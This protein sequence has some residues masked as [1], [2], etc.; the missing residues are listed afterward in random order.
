MKT[1]V[2]CLLAST[3]LF[4]CSCT[5]TPLQ[6]ELDR[7]DEV[8]ASCPIYEDR[9]SLEADRL[10]T[11]LDRAQGDSARWV[12]LDSLYRYYY[13]NSLDSAKL[14]SGKMM[15]EASTPG[16]RFVSRLGQAIILSQ[17]GAVEQAAAI[18]REIDTLGV[19]DSAL[20]R[21]YYH[22]GIIVYT[23][24][25]RGSDSPTEISQLRQEYARYRLELLTLDTLSAY[26]RRLKGQVQRN[27][28]KMEEA[29][30]TFSSLMDDPDVGFND[31]ASTAYNIATAHEMMGDREQQKLWLAR[32]AQYDFLAQD[33]E[34]LSLYS[35]AMLLYEDGDLDRAARY[36]QTNMM[37]VLDG[38]FNTRMS[39]SGKAQLMI[40]AASLRAEHRRR[41]LWL[42]LSSVITALLL[43]SVAF[44]LRYRSLSKRL[45]HLNADLTDAN[46]IK[47]NYVF[48]YMALSVN[49]LERQDEFRHSLLQT[50]KED[51]LP[52][53]RQRL[54]S[55]TESYQ[56][57]KEFYRIFDETFLGIYPDFVRRVNSLLKED[58]Q[59]PEPKG[60][61][62]TTEL[63]ILAAIRIGITDSGRIATFLKCSPATVY[64][65]RTKMRKWAVFTKEEFEERIKKI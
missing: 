56:A 53:V 43:V 35:L 22:S 17:F 5:R 8:I 63:R 54:R 26:A 34:Y 7:L 14:Y 60:K 13:H 30:C 24:L 51:G 37:D 21:E 46:I 32:S 44:F 62:L 27:S 16:Q 48:R 11:S 58:C 19:R 9:F 29:L 50:V 31:K 52:A 55:P 61:T 2:T 23:N 20:L 41:M 36:I 28:G 64:T 39:N 1:H 40:A 15:Q 57:F 12:V 49:Y 38:H 42:G 47:E 33:R 4:A 59:I 25:S 45:D 3:F 6:I 65:Y 10:R 18:F